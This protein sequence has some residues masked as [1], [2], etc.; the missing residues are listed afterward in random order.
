MVDN[1]KLVDKDGVK[2][3]KLCRRDIRRQFV[4]I[5]IREVTVSFADTFYHSHSFTPI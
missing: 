1:R 3:G 2:F 4:E 5:R